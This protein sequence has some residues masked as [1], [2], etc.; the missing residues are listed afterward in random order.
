MKPLTLRVAS[1]TSSSS[2]SYRAEACVPMSMPVRTF[3]LDPPP[4]PPPPPPSGSHE[5]VKEMEPLGGGVPLPSLGMEPLATPPWRGSGCS[6]CLTKSRRERPRLSPSRAPRRTCTS[7]SW[8]SE[9]TSSLSSTLMV[10]V[11]STKSASVPLNSSRSSQRGLVRFGT[12]LVCPR[13]LPKRTLAY[14]SDLPLLSAARSPSAHCTCTS[15]TP[16]C[17]RDCICGSWYGD[18]EGEPKSPSEPGNRCQPPFLGEPGEREPGD[19]RAS[20]PPSVNERTSVNERVSCGR[21]PEGVPS[22]SSV[23]AMSIACR[24]KSR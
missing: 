24:T 4:P 10:S 11:S 6:C 8:S 15:S 22:M 1:R 20:K 5:T 13:C 16:D 9:P 3:A 7:P 2:P 18:S 12:T 17:S 19:R 21:W 14:G 23:P